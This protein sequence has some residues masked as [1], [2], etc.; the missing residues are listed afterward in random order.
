[1]TG[2]IKMLAEA[3]AELEHTEPGDRTKKADLL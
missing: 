2:G 1:M 3:S